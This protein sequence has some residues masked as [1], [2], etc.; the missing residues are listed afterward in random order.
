MANLIKELIRELA[1]PI[2]LKLY[3]HLRYGR[4]KVEPRL[5]GLVV[6]NLSLKDRHRD[7]KRCFVLGNGPSLGRH[8]LS[9]LRGEIVFVCNFFNLHPQCH[10]VSPRYYC[11]HDPAAFFLERLNPDYEIDRSSWFADICAKIPDT[12]F[13]VPLDA[14]DRIES[15][16]WFS[17]HRIWYVPTNLTVLHRP[18]SAGCDLTCGIFGR[19]G[20]IPDLA[21]PAAIYMGFSSIYLLGCDCD[22]SLRAITGKGLNGEY[23]HFYDR[24]HFMRSEPNVRDSPIEA[25]LGWLVKHLGGLRAAM[26]FAKSKNVQIYNATPNGVLDIFPNI[27]LNEVLETAQKSSPKSSNYDLLKYNEAE[28][29]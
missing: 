10:R 8:D 11:L 9:Q 29:I 13:L 21:I 1:P 26:D 6:R 24:N 23:A 22:W 14:K 2:L 3:R 5:R 17:G 20:T 16:R 7:R 25:Q 27:D 12:E 15:N 19:Y 4:E 18:Y 28:G